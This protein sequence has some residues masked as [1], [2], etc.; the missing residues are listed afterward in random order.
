MN[1]KAIAVQRKEAASEADRVRS[2]RTRLKGA[3]A[4]A[5]AFSAFE[6]ILVLLGVFTAGRDFLTKKVDIWT[7]PIAVFT[8]PIFFMAR[9]TWKTYRRVR[10][11]L[12]AHRR[13]YGDDWYL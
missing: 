11:E 6:L 9:R 3:V 1:D 10:K 7:I 13:R 2:D 12:A 5:F 4:L 8:L